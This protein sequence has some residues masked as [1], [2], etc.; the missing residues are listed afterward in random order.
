VQDMKGSFE[1]I[2]TDN[3]SHKDKKIIELAK[4][5]RGLQLQVESLKTK[6]ASAAKI[7][8]NLSKEN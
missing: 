1:A 5:N 6:A 8:L 3:D 7:A 4:K 2:S